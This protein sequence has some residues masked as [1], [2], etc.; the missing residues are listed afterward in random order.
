MAQYVQTE[1]ELMV[2]HIPDI[3]SHAV[4]RHD[5]RLRLAGIELLDAVVLNGIAAVDQN[6]IRIFRAN[7]PDHGAELY[8]A[9]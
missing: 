6:R 5:H 3:V 1:V 2:A 7:L 8:H 9:A 4:H